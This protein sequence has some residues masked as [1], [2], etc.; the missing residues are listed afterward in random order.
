MENEILPEEIGSEALDEQLEEGEPQEPQE[1]DEP[2]IQAQEA[3]PP[4]PQP[5]KG[6]DYRYQSPYLS[7]PQAQSNV[8]A[9]YA[10]VLDDNQYAALREMASEIAEERVS[11]ALQAQAQQRAAAK[12]LGLPADVIDEYGD[13]M[14][15]HEMSVPSNLRGTK[16]GAMLSFNAA[17]TERMLQSGD[18]KG[19]LRQASA[20]FGDDQS[21]EVPRSKALLSPDQR[22]TSSKTSAR[23]VTAN[24]KDDTPYS[25]LKSSWGAN[26]E[27]MRALMEASEEI[28]VRVGGRR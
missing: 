16:E 24:R 14:R 19:V 25:R 2:Q 7:Q 26:D 5:N 17:L 9:K 11:L 15:R 6:P 27:E 18:I 8:P 28:G 23:P 1:G 22:M 13:D 3:A 20:Y 4:A 21:V 12:Q 10:H